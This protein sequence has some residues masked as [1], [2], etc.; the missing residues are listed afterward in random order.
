[1]DG[2]VDVS[3]VTALISYVLGNQVAPFNVSAANLTDDEDID[4]SDV[5]ALISIVLNDNITTTW[6]ALPAAR[7]IV[8]DNP[9]GTEI[10]IYDMEARL[11]ATTVTSSAF[12]LPAGI[13]IV[14]ADSGSRKVI[15]K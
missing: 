1:M 3:D 5:T 15:V 7:G 6:R 9:H 13:Y 10:A 8:V 11:V 4:I 2:Q 12:T 14:T